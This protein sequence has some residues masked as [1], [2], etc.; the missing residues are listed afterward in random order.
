[1]LKIFT[2]L[3]KNFED[4]VDIDLYKSDTPKEN[5]N[6]CSRHIEY[7]K[8]YWNSFYYGPYS[9]DDIKEWCKS[10]KEVEK[11]PYCNVGKDYNYYSLFKVKFDVCGKK[12]LLNMPYPIANRYL[13]YYCF[14]KDYKVVYEMVNAVNDPESGYDIGYG[15]T[16]KDRKKQIIESFDK[17]SEQL[18]DFVN[19]KE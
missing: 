3:C 7:F 8:D 12:F 13:P 18:K 5:V 6:L 4:K 1:M 17:I 16:N 9:K 10:N 14:S 2:F 11:C 19:N 15:F